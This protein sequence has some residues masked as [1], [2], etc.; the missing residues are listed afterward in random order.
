MKPVLILA[1]LLLPCLSA[2]GADPEAVH[3]WLLKENRFPE[4]AAKAK[5]GQTA[6]LTSPAT[7][8]EN[9]HL[10]FDG[11][12]ALEVAASDRNEL[13]LPVE[14]FT[15]EVIARI[16]QPEIYG[17]LIGYQQDNGAY[18]KGW[19]LGYGGSHFQ[20]K[21]STRTKLHTVTSTTPSRPNQWF[22][23]VG[24]YDGKEMRLYVNGKLEATSSD[25]QG[26]IAYPESAPF[27]LG[28]YKDND[29]F[30]PLKGRLEEAKLYHS[31]LTAEEIAIRAAKVK[32]Q[33]ARASL[34]FTLHP[35]L[36][37]LSPGTA[38]ITFATAARGPVQLRWGPEKKMTHSRVSRSEDG[39][40]EIIID[41]LSPATLYH[42]RLAEKANGRTVSSRLFEFDTTLNY[43]PPAIVGQAPGDHPEATAALARARTLDGFCLVY[44]ADQVPLL[45]ALADGS[46]FQVVAVD[47]RAE[48]IDQCRKALHHQKAYGP[49]ITCLQVKRL[50]QLPFTADFANL[51]VA[52]APPSESFAYSPEETW[53]VLRP[54]GGVATLPVP[55]GSEAWTD[56]EAFQAAFGKFTATKG[57]PE[58][59]G[60]WTHQYGDPSN[61]TNSGEVLA[62]AKTTDDLDVQWFGRPGADFGIDRNPRMPAPLAVNGRLFHQGMNRMI[63]LDAYNGTVLWALEIPDLRRVNIPRDASNW[64]ADDDQVYVAIKDQL[65]VL[66]A[67]S[68]ARV[69]VHRNPLEETHEWGY[70]AQTNDLLIGSS[71]KKG[72]I[73]T[74][75]W[76][77]A[78]W[79]DEKNDQATA[80]VCSNN[81]FAFSKKTGEERWL[82][83]NG[84]IVNT[85]ISA[86]NGKIFLTESRN[87]EIQDQATGRIASPKLWE[88]FYLVCLD[89]S[90][91]HVLW[92]KPIE[93][94]KKS[95][96][97]FG[98]YTPEAMIVI[99]SNEG[100]FHL[101]A[102]DPATGE[103]KWKRQN[104]WADDHHSGHMQ[105]PV[106]VN[107]VLYLQPYGMDLET[108]E[109][110]TEKMGKR[111]GCHTY[112]GARDALVFRG[113]NRQ[114]SMWSLEEEETTTWTRL[115]PSCWL[116][117]VP[118][119]G[120]LLM[121]EGGGG[122][123]C[124]NWME[125]SIA[126]R[127][128]VQP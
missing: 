55:E 48:V 94:Q 39:Y 10:V 97:Y 11:R 8:D 124:G 73:F 7:F 32:G 16:D 46:R 109:L 23:V 75:F 74:D 5:S 122:C 38:R 65:W 78:S 62:G 15:A 91:G 13:R 90:T 59:A 116:S 18:E 101:Q 58:G 45:Q 36:Q 14:S 113:T 71:V 64:C 118:A 117:I 26:P 44:G 35:S 80:K 98:I 34:A 99:G 21:V 76:S 17:C 102:Y 30:F 69:R 68:G 77:G 83:Q 82:Y 22:H 100:H 66:N 111:E 67:A 120:L 63:A 105:H 2:F 121:P 119:G 43:S 40:H 12:Q 89:E 29:E 27:M 51:I 93:T 126:F 110:T 107:G 103:L 104:K 72:S 28:A 92:E 50:D 25:N 79:Y 70:V 112:V 33:Q 108:G 3:D 95:I 123:S 86:G 47:T 53:R 84:T 1:L 128:I 49:R 127:P 96:S 54:A 88:D 106:A 52:S 61:D 85:S 9:G 60:S 57:L 125:T 20:L 37:F 56:H 114:V 6:T 19:E 41:Q 31:V 87:A 42:Y 81:L 115:R 24:V 4:G